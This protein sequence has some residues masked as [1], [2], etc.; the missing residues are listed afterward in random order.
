MHKVLF[1]RLERQRKSNCRTYETTL[2]Y[3]V[4]TICWTS[5]CLSFTAVLL[6]IGYP[7]DTNY[8]PTYYQEK[9]ARTDSYI[10]IYVHRQQSMHSD[11]RWNSTFRIGCPSS[12]TRSMCGLKVAGS[13]ILPHACLW[14]YRDVEGDRAFGKWTNECW[15]PG[16]DRRHQEPQI[17]TPLLQSVHI[18]RPLRKFHL[19]SYF[20]C[21]RA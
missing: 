14:W 8:P 5:W 18:L 19:V 15:P 10:A 20:S 7:V 17:S 6:D 9:T 2:G 21:T 1:R 4:W 13:T 11:K 3:T 12:P 16:T